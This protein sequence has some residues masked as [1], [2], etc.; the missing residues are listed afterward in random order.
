MEFLII[1][2]VVFIVIILIVSKPQKDNYGNIIEN[3]YNTGE[4][5]VTLDVPNPKTVDSITFLNFIRDCP[6]EYAYQIEYQLFYLNKVEN[7]IYK[8]AIREKSDQGYINYNYYLKV[9]EKIKPENYQIN[10]SEIDNNYNFKT[11]FKIAGVHIENRKE[12]LIFN[13]SEGESLILK[14]EP[15]NI[16]DE[17]AIAIFHEKN[18][19]GY[20][21]RTDIG[22]ISEII[23]F[24]HI[25]KISD[26]VYKNDYLDVFV[27]LYASDEENPDK[28]YYLDSKTLKELQSRKIDS[29]YLRPKKDAEDV[30]MFFKK[31]V[32]ITGEFTRFPDR[33]ELAEILYESGADIDTIITEKTHYIIKGDY[34]GWKKLEKANDY[35][36]MIF[37]EEEIIKILGL[38]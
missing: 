28:K 13:I 3:N 31:K 6:R 32:V 25:A 27:N 10:E 7:I 21:P 22:E 29:K 34:A 33:N 2:F 8:R 16:Y 5:T 1:I 37:S 35:G 4:K 26:I 18:L 20:V 11:T 38:E 36:I 9:L 12:N 24:K 14:R 17:N 19:I 15:N 23:K 30:N